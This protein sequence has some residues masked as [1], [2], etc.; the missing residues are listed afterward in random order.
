MSASAV[1]TRLGFEQLTLCKAPSAENPGLSKVLSFKPPADHVALRASPAARNLA[2]Q[3]PEFPL[4]PNPLPK[5]G[6][7][8]CEVTQ[9]F[10]IHV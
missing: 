3:L 7:A 4:V 8:Y 2:F 5:Q 6:N 1:L 10:N 9:T